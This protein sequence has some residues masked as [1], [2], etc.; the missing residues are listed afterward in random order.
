ME[1]YLEQASVYEEY[2]VL[3][4]NQGLGAYEHIEDNGT[5]KAM[6]KFDTLDD[7]IKFIDN[8]EDRR[9]IIERGR[10]GILSSD[11]VVTIY[12]DYIE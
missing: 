4:R 7:L 10:D 9:I 2:E 6:V 8:T 11:L 5:A 12:D 3:K 1:F